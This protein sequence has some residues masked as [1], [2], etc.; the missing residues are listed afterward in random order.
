MRTGATP[1][2]L[3]QRGFVGGSIGVDALIVEGVDPAEAKVSLYS[4]IHGARRLFGRKEAKRRFT[5][6]EMEVWLKSRGVTLIGADLD[7]RRIED[8]RRHRSRAWHMLE[9]SPSNQKASA[10]LRGANF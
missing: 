6:A 3:G 7:E 8:A 4:T 2:F 10:S 5:R 1:A 9:P